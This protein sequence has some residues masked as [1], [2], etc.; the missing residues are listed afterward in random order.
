M[1]TLMMCAWLSATVAPEQSAPTIGVGLDWSKQIFVQEF[2]TGG[3]PFYAVVNARPEPVELRIHEYRR[4]E[5]GALLL[6]PIHLPAKGFERVP[7][8]RLIGPELLLFKTGDGTTLGVLQ[9]PRRNPAGW[10]APDADRA[11]ITCNGLN[12]SGGLRMDLATYQGRMEYSSGA[13]FRLSLSLPADVGVVSIPRHGPK[14]LPA[15][16]TVLAA[17]SK[18]LRVSQDDRAFIIDTTNPDSSQAVHWVVLTLKAPA[19]RTPTMAVLSGRL[20]TQVGSVGI[21]RGI[22]IVP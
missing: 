3:E 9:A 11:I 12:G 22:V 20:K 13:E 16:V 2:W 15:S 18:T 14:E 5:A 7:A 19:V 21:T 10:P 8:A 17:E 4:A 1:G 6:E